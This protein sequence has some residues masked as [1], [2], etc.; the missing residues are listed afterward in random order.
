VHEYDVALKRILTRPGSALLYALTGCKRLRWLN[1][2]LPKVNNP[3]IDLLGARPDGELVHLE[4]QSRSERKLAVRMG[5]YLFAIAKRYGRIPRQV[6]LYV[7]EKRTHMNTRLTSPDL[8]Y[9]FHLIDI[10][11]LD[12][13]PLL[14]SKNLSDNVSAVLTRLGE[15]PETLRQ[16]LR[17]IQ[18]APAEERS[19]ALAELSILAGLRKLKDN[20]EQE[21]TR[22]PITEDIMKNP[23]VIRFIEH[24]RELE[25]EQA[26]A[27]QSKMLAGQIRKRFGVLPNP[28]RRRLAAM[29]SEELTATGL[30]LFDAATIDDLFTS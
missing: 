19:E 8:D 11:D 14:A 5:E 22:M 6:V 27:A 1:V 15:Q 3:R 26:R 13:E 24:G 18:G 20:I 9:R 17:R 29:T 30:R 25:R 12:G 4:F 2:E 28:A 16:I 23:M 7:G 10:R 21:R